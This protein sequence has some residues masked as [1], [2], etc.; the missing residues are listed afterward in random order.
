MVLGLAE[1]SEEA[2]ASTGMAKGAQEVA[3]GGSDFAADSGA[4][5]GESGH[6]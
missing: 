6:R 3:H 5:D 4:G 1:V 2:A